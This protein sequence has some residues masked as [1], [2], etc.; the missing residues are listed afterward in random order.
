MKFSQKIFE[1]WRFWKM[2]I[3]KNRPFWIVFL[4]KKFF[5]ASFSWKSVQICMVDWMGQNFDVFPV[6]SKFLA[7][8]N[9]TL[10]SVGPY[11]SEA[12]LF[13]GESWHKCLFFWHLAQH[14]WYKTLWSNL[15]K[16][17]DLLIFCMYSQTWQ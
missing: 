9:K 1:N 15:P 13:S 11:T 16:L 17:L 7:M 8:L 4:Q 2:T 14:L 12:L 5:F 10:Y 3:L 6:S